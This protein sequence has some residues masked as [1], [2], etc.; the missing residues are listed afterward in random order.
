[1]TKK[2]IIALVI[3]TLFLAG[4]DIEQPTPTPEERPTATAEV[5]EAPTDSPPEVMEA[6]LTEGGVLISEVLTGVPG[7]NNQEF[8]ELYNAGSE[9]VDLDG[10]S[11]WYLLGEGQT[12]A[13]VFSWD[14]RN[15]IPGYGHLLLI[16]A[17]KEFG[18]IADGIFDVALSEFKGGLLLKD[19]NE[20]AVDMV[21]WGDAPTSYVAGNPADAPTPGSSLRRLPG[22]ELGNGQDSGDNSADFVVDGSPNPQNSGSPAEPALNN[23]LT[24]RMVFPEAVEPGAFI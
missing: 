9:A 6:S 7:G 4:C 15:D 1:M 11:L 5:V 12:E 24:V 18:I 10:W 16:R 14:G 23:L 8:I 2:L 17:E 19:S 20:E 13:L 22:G 3:G 21:G